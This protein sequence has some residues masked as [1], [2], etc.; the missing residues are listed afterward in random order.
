MKIRIPAENIE[1]LSKKITALANKAER[2]NL[3]PIT[4]NVNYAIGIATPDKKK[5]GE[6]KEQE[7]FSVDVLGEPP[8]LEGWKF[9]GIV[10]PTEQGNLLIEINPENKI[11]DKYRHTDL[12]DCEHCGIKRERLSAF[13]VQNNETQEVLQV[14]RVCLKS[15]TGDTD[16]K[17]IALYESFFK[18][19]EFEKI[20]SYGEYQPFAFKP[21]VVLA[22][23]FK[24][25]EMFPNLSKNE[26]RHIALNSIPI[27]RNDGNRDYYSNLVDIRYAVGNSLNDEDYK[28]AN[29]F[30][31]SMNNLDDTG[32]NRIWN[33]KLVLNES[34]T[35]HSDVVIQAIEFKD[36]HDR[37]LTIEQSR[38]KE[39]LERMKQKEDILEAKKTRIH[40]GQEQDKI[41]FHVR[42]ENC[43]PK[44]SE[45]GTTYIH[46]F[47]DKDE[48]NIT[49]FCTGSPLFNHEESENLKKDKTFFY[50][51]GT[52][53]RHQRYDDEPQTKILRVKFLGFEK[54][55]PVVKKTKKNQNVK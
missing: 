4:M 17:N 12:C 42:L 1:S 25:K 47:R 22:Y 50:I 20:N 7:Y 53:G 45:F 8:I 37:Y 29:D 6:F 54:P 33:Y 24:S 36:A 5:P 30:I 26:L 34:Y 14:G 19:K 41:D 38:L 32:N 11:P 15:Y 55:E 39:Q 3:P 2:L 51:H 52:I 31:T 9:I 35:I 28:K 10:E 21:E 46:T 18:L 48:N 40:I 49:W 44:A 13:I 16:P 27:Y 23:Y 43:F